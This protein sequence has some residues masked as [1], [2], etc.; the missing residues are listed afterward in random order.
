MGALA[1]AHRGDADDHT[2]SRPG[3]PSL[4]LNLAL[5]VLNLALARIGV[6]HERHADHADRGLVDKTERLLLN[7]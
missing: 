1:G 7:R 3:L 4:V 6:G 2:G 5:R